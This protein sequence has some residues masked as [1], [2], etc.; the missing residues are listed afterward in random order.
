MVIFS[1]KPGNFSNSCEEI[2]SFKGH[3]E[4]ALRSSENLRYKLNSINSLLNY[5]HTCDEPADFYRSLGLYFNEESRKQLLKKIKAGNPCEN[6][7]SA[8]IEKLHRQ[9]EAID[10]DLD[11]IIE[12]IIAKAEFFEEEQRNKIIRICEQ[13]PQI[14][15]EQ[16]HLLYQ[17]FVG[18]EEELLN[19]WEVIVLLT[20]CVKTSIK[21]KKAII[22]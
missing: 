19:R 2:T 1:K 9:H 15:E 16:W 22:N 7:L 6:E 3:S 8:C 11:K 12:K 18:K 20:S 4:L 10:F 5:I 13:M 14:D 21:N 17:T